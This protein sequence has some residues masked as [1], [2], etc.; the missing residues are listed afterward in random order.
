[1]KT[2]ADTAT[3]SDATEVYAHHVNTSPASPRHYMDTR[4]I[5]LYSCDRITYVHTHAQYILPARCVWLSVF[6]YEREENHMRHRVYTA[7]VYVCVCVYDADHGDVRS[8]HACQHANTCMR[9]AACKYMHEVCSMQIH[10]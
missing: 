7:C 4:C 10:A 6:M 5:H 8:M 9:S 1:V 2:C 3:V